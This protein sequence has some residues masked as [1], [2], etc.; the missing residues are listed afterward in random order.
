[1]NV[2]KS[3]DGF[4]RFSEAFFTERCPVG[5]SFQES[6]NGRGY[7]VLTFG[8][9]GDSVD[10]SWVK[11][12]LLKDC[13]QGWSVLR[14]IIGFRGSLDPAV[15][16]DNVSRL[17]PG[18]TETLHSLRRMLGLSDTLRRPFDDITNGRRPKRPRRSLLPS[19]MPGHSSKDH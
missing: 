15:F 16:Y 10:Q 17:V 8:T 1:M 7:R 19:N 11:V 3:T 13:R 14:T 5:G 2:Y 9:D 12:A 6:T 4:H 18:E